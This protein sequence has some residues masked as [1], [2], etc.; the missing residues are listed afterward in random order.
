MT[1]LADQIVQISAPQP[2]TQWLY[3]G[4]VFLGSPAG[5]LGAGTIG[6]FPDPT[7]ARDA[8]EALIR[9]KVRL[10][11]LSRHV[12]FEVTQFDAACISPKATV[13][14][15]VLSRRAHDGKADNWTLLVGTSDI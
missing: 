1:I 10:E 4:E 6:P 11:N 5:P 15:A 8:V 14:G 2:E 3:E 9:T 7:S 12:D 13:V